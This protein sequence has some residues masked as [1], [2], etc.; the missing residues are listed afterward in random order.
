MTQKVHTFKLGFI[1]F[2][3]FSRGVITE[4]GFLLIYHLLINHLIIKRAL[5]GIALENIYFKAIQYLH[6]IDSY[7][8]IY[9]YMANCTK[10]K[11]S[12]SYV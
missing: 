7:T 9:V 3:M 5:G 10:Q 11:Y 12:I 6:G 1:F 2:F 4:V 8:I